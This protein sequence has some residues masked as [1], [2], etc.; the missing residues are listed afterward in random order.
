MQADTTAER[1]VLAALGLILQQ[2][3]KRTSLAD[4]AFHAGVT[5]ITVYRYYGD[6]KGLVRA[7]CMRIAAIFRAAAEGGPAESIRDMDQR[8]NRLGT[9]LSSLP[10]GDLLAR[11]EEINRQYPDVYEEFRATRQTA[12]DAIF[13]QAVAAA[14][15]E[16]T[17]REGLNPEVL[18]VIFWAAVVG[19]FENPT[20]ISSN[21]PLAEIFATVTEVFRHGILK[22]SAGAADHG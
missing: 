22:D 21:I 11:L 2:G 6:K 12:V 16:G 5:R 17:L 20:L 15:R 9:Q 3:V 10:K 7:V 8:L 4:V 14:T 13:Q 18:K 19:L 1:I